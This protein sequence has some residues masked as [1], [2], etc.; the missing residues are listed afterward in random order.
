MFV[1]SNYNYSWIFT[2]QILL[3]LANELLSL[4]LLVSNQPNKEK[5]LKIG[6]LFEFL[7]RGRQRLIL[8]YAYVC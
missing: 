3:T 4:C 5:S 7:F 8:F 2:R 1:I 6:S